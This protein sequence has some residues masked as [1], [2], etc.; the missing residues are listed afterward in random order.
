MKKIVLL[1]AIAISVMACNKSSETAGFKTAYVDTNKMMVDYNEAKEITDQFKTK[2]E[3]MGREL[4]V[5]AKKLKSEMDNFQKN[6]QINGQAWAQQNGSRLQ[7]REQQLNYAQ[8]AM[9]QQLQGEHGAKMD[10]IIKSVKEFI[11][12]YG[13]KEG[14]DYIYGTGD[15]ATVLYAKDSYDLTKTITKALN[16]KYAAAA[17]PAKTEE[18]RK[19]RNNLLTK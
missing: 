6:A 16:D 4:E 11:K 19:K 12:E 13:K 1:A 18:K 9:L 7:Q 17:K 10:T 15:A 14:Y 2:G 8:Q 5:E 3:V